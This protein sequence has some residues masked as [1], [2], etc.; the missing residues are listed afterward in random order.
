MNDASE[1]Y[2]TCMTCRGCAR[3]IAKQGWGSRWEAWLTPHRQ[4]NNVA[5]HKF[6][7][8][9]RVQLTTMYTSGLSC[10]PKHRSTPN[11]IIFTGG[12]ISSLVAMTHVEGKSQVTAMMKRR[13]DKTNIVGG[14]CRHITTGTSR[15][16]GR[17]RSPSRSGGCSPGVGRVSTGSRP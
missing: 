1:V 12:Q 3:N 16:K 14:T 13:T 4:H 17:A 5:E 8:P 15:S 10:P 6:A 7:R 2:N 11:R 9:Q